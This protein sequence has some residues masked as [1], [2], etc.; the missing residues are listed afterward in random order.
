[1]IPRGE[2]VDPHREELI[3]DIR[4]DTEASGSVLHIGHYQVESGL[5]S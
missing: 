3:G 5:V 1:M 4:G 2:N